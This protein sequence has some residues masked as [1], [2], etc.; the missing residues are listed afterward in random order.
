MQATD[1]VRNIAGHCKH[2][3]GYATPRDAMA[4]PREQIVY[5]P[6]IRTNTGSKKPDYV[7]TVDVD[8]KSPT[9]SQVI[10]RLHMP[11]IGDELHHTGWNACSSCYGDCSKSRNRLIVPGFDS[12]R[13]YVI[14]VGTQPRAP[15]IHKIVEPEEVF[16]KAGVSVPHTTHCLGSGEVM[17]STLGNVDGTPRGGFILLD[18]E[19]FRVKGKWEKDGKGVPMGYDFWYQP[20]HNVLMSTEWG[21]PNAFR[22]GFQLED[23]KAGKYGSHIHVWDWTTHEKIQTIDLGVGTIPLEIRFLHDPSQAQGFVGCALSSTIVRFF[24]NPDNTWGN[25][26]V[27][28]V[29]P[30]KVEGW[31]LPEMPGLITDIL[32]SLDDKYLYFSN[33]IQGDLRQYDIT[34]PRNPKLTGQVFI[35]GSMTRSSGVRVIDDPEL[36]QQPDECYIKGKKVE[37]GP[38]MI[39][40]SLDGKRLYVTTS[41]YSNWDNQFY[42]NLS[43]KGAMLLIVDV[44]TVNGGLYLNRDFL[45]DFGA[46]P[47]G[48]CLAH[49]VRYPGGDCSSDIWI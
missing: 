17:I 32:I 26:T 36:P 35:G 49:E 19:T 3:P 10:H 20:R 27:I 9:Y 47:D 33:W 31:A 18:G 7:S 40:L 41:L 11:Y 25:E 37:G 5:L 43:K 22:R 34:D 48:P 1:R 46:E 38:Q 39:Q 16:S 8:P 4:G 23:F 15:R 45:V 29:P 21:E 44:D 12:T 14:D 2:G 30:K 24:K 42:P 13:I 6:C 28:R